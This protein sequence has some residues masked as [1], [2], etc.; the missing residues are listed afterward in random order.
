[1]R[2]A[3][4]WASKGMVGTWDRLG[5]GRGGIWID[6][7]LS[8]ASDFV[9]GGG[10]TE[11]HRLERHEDGFIDRPIKKHRQEAKSIKKEW[12]D[13]PRQLPRSRSY[14]KTHKR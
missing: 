8:G 2:Q 13:I 5:V 4:R 1:M 6:M 14:G 11:R 7:T 3:N 9:R 10:D 12:L